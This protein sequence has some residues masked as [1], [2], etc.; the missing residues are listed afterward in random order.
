LYTP[1]KEATNLWLEPVNPQISRQEVHVWRAEFNSTPTQIQKYVQTLSNDE[2][3]RVARFQFQK[4][5]CRFIAAR[6]ILRMLLGRYLGIA[7][8][9]VRFR[10]NLYGKPALTPGINQRGLT[11]NLAHSHEML[12]LAVSRCRSLGIDVEYL[13]YD[14]PFVQLAEQFFSPQEIADLNATPAQQRKQAFYTVWTLK[15]AY[16][17]M[18]GQGLSIPLDQF[19]I[20]TPPGNPI[21]LTFHSGD[22]FEAIRCCLRNI[23]PGP[24]YTAALAAEGKSLDLRCWQWSK[25]MIETTGW[26]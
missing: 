16:I 6:G 24:G 5:R 17:K 14:L 20:S 26:S 3:E 1:N 4:H 12:L 13:R 25:K 2:L 11:F 8:R 18:R 15:E 21:S 23:E 7:A 9:Q 22:P 19:S 10:Y